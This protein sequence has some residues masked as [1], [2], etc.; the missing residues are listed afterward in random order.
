[1]LEAGA[2]GVIVSLPG[3]QAMRELARRYHERE[4]YARSTATPWR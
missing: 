4:A 2:E 3:E 1:M